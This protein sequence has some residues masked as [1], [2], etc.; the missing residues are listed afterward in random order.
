[1]K[2]KFSPPTAAEIATSKRLRT[3]CDWFNELN[4]RISGSQPETGLTENVVQDIQSQNFDRG[5]LMAIRN[6]PHKWTRHDPYQWL[7]ILHRYQNKS[8]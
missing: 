1:M 3:I 4:G 6:T 8:A 5:D 2:T 7:W